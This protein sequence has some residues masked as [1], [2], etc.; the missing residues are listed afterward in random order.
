MAKKEQEPV[1]EKEAIARSARYRDKVDLVN[2]LLEDDKEYTL[3]QVD[4]IIEDYM[5][6]EVK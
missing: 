2:G 4:K 3:E 6:K 1:F 5:N